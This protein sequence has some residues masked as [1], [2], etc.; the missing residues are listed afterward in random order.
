VEAA[1]AIG[2]PFRQ[3]MSL[4]VLPQSLRAVI[5]PLGGL[6]IAL[7]KNSSIAAAFS[8]TEATQ[9]ARRLSNSFGSATLTI[10]GGIAIG[11][12]LITVCVSYGTS[13]LERRTAIAR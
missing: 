13:W 4:V 1:R 9:V 3:I 11:Y 8:V 12:L 7:V 10:L 6:I 5:P 2:L